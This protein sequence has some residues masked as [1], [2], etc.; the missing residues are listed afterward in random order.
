MLLKVNAVSI[1]V[2]GALDSLCH[3][4]FL[5]FP[6][7]HSWRVRKPFG[8]PREAI[9]LPVKRTAN[10]TEPNSAMCTFTELE[11]SY[12]LKRL[13]HDGSTTVVPETMSVKDGIL[14]E[15]SP[16]Y[17]GES[18]PVDGTAT[19]GQLR[20]TLMLSCSFQ[21][22]TGASIDYVSLKWWGFNQDTEG[23][24]GTHASEG[25]FA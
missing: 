19:D 16:I 6:K 5:A 11:S 2:P 12:R 18:R 7:L 23:G 14:A 9:G 15:G 20:T 3:S 17:D 8:T 13:G 21:G 1:W 25:C 24:D 10:P 22:W 4:P